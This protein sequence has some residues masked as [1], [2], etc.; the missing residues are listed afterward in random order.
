[1][2]LDK[3]SNA[4]TLH[5]IDFGIQYGFQWPV[6]IQCLSMRPGG[7]PKLRITGIEL[8][9]SG[10]R[11]ASRTC[12]SANTKMR[13]KLQV[14]EETIRM[15]N[16]AAFIYR[17]ATKDVEYKGYTIPRGWKVMIVSSS[18]VTTRYYDEAPLDEFGLFREPK[19]GQ[20]RDVHR[21]LKLSK[22]ALLW[23]ER[24][25]KK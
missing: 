9:Q 11:Q 6:L 1:M 20:L 14:V 8:P 16:I 3:A 19:F 5:I 22:K 15:A 17:T 24:R 12:A 25:L 18:F 13:S 2:I 21:A 4:A 10:F 7:P 23:G